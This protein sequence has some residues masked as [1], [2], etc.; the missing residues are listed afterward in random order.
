MACDDRYL[1]TSPWFFLFLMTIL[2]FITFVI[3]IENNGQFKNGNDIPSWL[4]MM[5]IFIILFLFVSFILYYYHIKNF[6]CP[7][8]VTPITQIQP[9]MH[10]PVYTPVHYQE[11]YLHESPCSLSYNQSNLVEQE[12]I[13]N[14]EST[15]YK[16]TDTDISIPLSA[17]NPFV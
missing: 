1:Y 15:T 13:T 10:Y 16:Y 14:A 11:P 12:I 8:I 2:L 6:K 7:D 3:V 4:W 17:L 9:I 5:F